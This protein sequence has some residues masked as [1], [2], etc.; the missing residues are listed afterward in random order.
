MFDRGLDRLQVRIGI[1]F[2]FCHA[3]F[4]AEVIGRSLVGVR[5]GRGL[6]ID[7]HSAN[8]VDD[9]LGLV[10]FVAKLM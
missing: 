10:V 6:W 8:R 7:S 5:S 3:V 2:E 9:A 4:A 1:R